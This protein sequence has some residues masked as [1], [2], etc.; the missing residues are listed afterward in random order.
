[1]SD[2]SI[3]GIVIFIIGFIFLLIGSII[4][5]YKIGM[6]IGNSKNTSLQSAITN[7]NIAGDVFLV[8]GITL[9]IIVTGYL[10]VG[11]ESEHKSY[12]HN[13]LHHIDHYNG[14]HENTHSNI[15]NIDSVEDILTKQIDD[16][17]KHPHAKGCEKLLDLGEQI[18]GEDHNN[19]YV[20]EDTK[21]MLLD[22]EWKDFCGELKPTDPQYGDYKETCEQYT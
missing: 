13:T 20:G 12:D 7:C 8:L 15:H 4:L 17:T 6:S 18:V 9:L 3:P 14:H 1:M 16:C 11:E 2:L 21:Q 10:M 22:E 5:G 19:H